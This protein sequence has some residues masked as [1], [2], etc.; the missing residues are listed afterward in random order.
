MIRPLLVFVLL[1]MIE[2]L[3]IVSFVSVKDRLH[4]I[5]PQ[6]HRVVK[7][8]EASHKL[9]MFVAGHLLL[10]FPLVLLLNHLVSKDVL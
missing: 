4:F 5:V 9:T 10:V 2:R 1:S 6:L 8:I 7:S 3:Q